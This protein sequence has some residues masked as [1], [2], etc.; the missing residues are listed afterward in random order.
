[1]DSDHTGFSGT[2]FC[3][4]DNA[5]G[6][7]MTWTVSASSTGTATVTFRYSNGTT[8]SRPAS[9]L[10]NGVALSTLDF[11]VTA[12][13]DTWANAS[14]TVPLHAG[15][16][17]IAAAA[18]TAG[19]APNLDYVDVGPVTGPSPSPPTTPYDAPYATRLR[20]IDSDHTGF[21][22]TGFCNTDNVSGASMTWT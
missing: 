3:N 8:G 21:S 5:S 2:G 19:G 13:W 11:P 7:S 22:G 4:T 1:I 20:S 18:T 9:I 16:N 6:A 12:H 15:S 17:T 10:E 14:L